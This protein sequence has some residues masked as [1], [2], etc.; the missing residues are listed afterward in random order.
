MCVVG[1]SHDRSL[2]GILGDWFIDKFR[3][4]LEEFIN[5]VMILFVDVVIKVLF[6]GVE[7]LSSISH[8]L[9]TISKI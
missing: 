1:S 6:F 2:L 9:N 8:F 5:T 7:G 3:V 4:F